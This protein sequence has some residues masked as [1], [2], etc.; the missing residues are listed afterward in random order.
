[1]REVERIV[2]QNI[3]YDFYGELLTEHQRQIYE[4][5]IF[6]DLSLSEISENY[7]ITRQGAHDVIKRCD[8][9]LLGYEE[10][11]HLA[12]RFENVRD[13]A[14]ELKQLIAD[15]GGNQP[16]GTLNSGDHSDIKRALELIERILNGI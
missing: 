8:K 2:R 16:V 3:L 13:C 10:K 4:D 5:A 9:A 6:N 15:A 1:M 11:L 14:K 7:G 12:E